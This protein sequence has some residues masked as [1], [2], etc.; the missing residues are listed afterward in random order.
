MSESLYLLRL[1]LQ[2]P[3]S[4]RRLILLS[5]ALSQGMMTAWFELVHD[6]L[7]AQRMHETGLGLVTEGCIVVPD[8]MLISILSMLVEALEMLCTEAADALVPRAWD[9]KPDNMLSHL[10]LM[11]DFRN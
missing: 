7:V 3:G 6:L 4:H 10:H 11:C 2:M 5:P 9:L 8:H 1:P